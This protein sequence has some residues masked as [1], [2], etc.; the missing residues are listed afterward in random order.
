VLH[1]LYGAGGDGGPP[2][3]IL[4]RER[5]VSRGVFGAARR[6]GQHAVSALW[7]L[8]TGHGAHANEPNAQAVAYY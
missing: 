2:V 5:W 3:R 1:D 8:H 6:F 4:A 7:R